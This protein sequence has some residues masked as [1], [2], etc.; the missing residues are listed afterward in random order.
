MSAV[1][2]SC[3]GPS[4]SSMCQR[5]AQVQCKKLFECTP[6]AA[7][8]QGFGSEADCRRQLEA[9]INCAQFDTITCTGVDLG[10]L[11]RC[12]ND[13][14]KLACTATSQPESCRGIEQPNSARCTSSDGKVFCTGGSSSSNSGGCSL[15]RTGCNDGKSYTLACAS[16]T[17]SCSVDGQAVKTF[18]GSSCGDVAAINAACGWNL[19]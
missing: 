11:D 18:A 10:P 16:G 17:C 8:A 6:Q 4:L 12:L 9:R 2:L 19:R 7:A 15:G 3:G 14:D 13:M 1:L 5:T